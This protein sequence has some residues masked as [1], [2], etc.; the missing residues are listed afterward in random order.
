MLFKPLKGFF[1]NCRKP[2]SGWDCIKIKKI[3]D[4][5][6]SRLHHYSATEALVYPVG[7]PAVTSHVLRM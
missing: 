7:L 4:T 2:A 3:V 5:H 1:K 6:H